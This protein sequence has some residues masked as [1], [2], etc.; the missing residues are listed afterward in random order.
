MTQALG[1]SG[2]L[3]PWPALGTSLAEGTGFGP[4]IPVLLWVGHNRWLFQWHAGS[5]SPACASRFRWDFLLMI[6]IPPKIIRE[7]GRLRLHSCLGMYRFSI[8]RKMNSTEWED[9][10]NSIFKEKWLLL[11]FW[12]H[13]KELN[14]FIMTLVVIWTCHR[15]AQCFLHRHGQWNGLVFVRRNLFFNQQTLQA[16][17]VVVL[18]GVTLLLMLKCLT[19]TV[20]PEEKDEKIMII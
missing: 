14:L 17:G 13:L 11:R 18:M 6:L 20:F 16:G 1:Q 4:C 10:G 12:N 3:S 7:Q 9:R 2:D 19:F 8:W 15:F 5:C